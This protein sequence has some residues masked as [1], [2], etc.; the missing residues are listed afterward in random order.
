MQKKIYLFKVRVCDGCF[1]K[2]PSGKKK[3]PI[4]ASSSVVISGQPAPSK[5]NSVSDPKKLAE[6]RER[7]LEQ[8][9]E[10]EINLAIALSQS[11]AEAKVRFLIFIV[12]KRIFDLHF[13]FFP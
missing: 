5:N 12:R 9:E 7:E 4:D 6:I 1:D 11:E 8:A 10:D 13:I 2:T 3:L